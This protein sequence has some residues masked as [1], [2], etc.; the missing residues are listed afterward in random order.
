MKV[1]TIVGAL[2][3]VGRKRMFMKLLQHAAQQL[4]FGYLDDDL[5]QPGTLNAIDP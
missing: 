4:Y 1:L 2:Q 5:V 3:V